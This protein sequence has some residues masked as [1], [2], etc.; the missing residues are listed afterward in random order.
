ME[1]FA[2][3]NVSGG[4][5]GGAAAR[6]TGAA[7]GGA[8]ARVRAGWRVRVGGWRFWR[9]GSCWGWCGRAGGVGAAVGG[10]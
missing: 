9:T 1:T 5:A 4:A 8:A 6:D 3:G 10:V 7:G 2:V